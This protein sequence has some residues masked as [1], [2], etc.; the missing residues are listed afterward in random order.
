M[1]KAF[2][3]G[4][5][6]FVGRHVAEVLLG[7]GWQLHALKRPT[8]KRFWEA[9]S[10]L[11]WFEGDIRS[12][13]DVGR[14]MK[15]CSVVFH[16][17]A[18]YRLWCQNPEEIYENNVR[19]TEVILAEAVRQDVDRFIYTSTV[20][21]LGHLAN[22]AS[23]CEHTP[24][25][26][27]DMVGHYKRS[28]YL[29]ERRVEDYLARGL[30]VVM[31]HP[32]TPIGPG[33]HKPTPTGKMIVDFLNGKIPAYVETGLNLVHVR[34]VAVGHHLAYERGNVGE[35]YILGNRNLSLASMFQLLEKLTGRKAP[36]V[37]LPHTAVLMLAAMEHTRSRLTQAE[38]LICLEAVRMARR[39]MF[40]DAGKAVAELGLPQTPV[41][42]ALID[43]VEWYVG[44]GYVK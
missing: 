4:A 22:G 38:P 43:A 36:R 13:L 37:K 29:A 17:A 21:A 10:G 1:P 18:D 24:V 33:D 12:P 23:S 2:I 7:Q 31:V 3:T 27:S 32:S 5:T 26:L 39:H 25:C 20:G 30:P 35:K 42:R 6:G 8:S 9:W 11:R 34:D 16:V 41:E 40:F 28:K 14:A 44:N 15:G 19:G